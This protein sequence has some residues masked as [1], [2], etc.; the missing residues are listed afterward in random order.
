MH[1]DPWLLAVVLGLL[2]AVAHRMGDYHLAR[3]LLEESLA[4]CR[5]IRDYAN[6]AQALASLGHL[7][8]AIGDHRAARE[9]YEDSLR[10]YRVIGDRR[11]IALTL[12]NLGVVAEQEGDR[13]GARRLYEESLAIVRAIGNPRAL[14]AVLGRLA[15]LARAQG[16][17]SA[18]RAAYLECL[19][20]WLQLGDRRAVLRCLT[21]CACLLATEQPEPALRLCAAAE[22]L[23]E[24]L[25][26][27]PPPAEWAAVERAVTALRSRLGDGP[28]T[29]AGAAGR[30]LS[31]EAAIALARGSLMA[32]QHAP[33]ETG[34]RH[35]SGV[36]PAASRLSPREREVAVLVAHGRTN[37][38]IAGELMI[39]E[40]T[41]D[42]H[43]TNILNKLGFATRAQIAAW[44]VQEGLM[45]AALVEQEL[46]A[47]ST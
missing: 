4:I 10:L 1:R 12:G 18:T 37:R 2:G 44:A 45:T 32:M 11:G 6:H 26:A 21:D 5:E 22:A 25:E 34:V 31:L 28:A 17:L 40:R 29:A 46:S 33:Q 14:P 43:L 24:Q 7:E 13:S 42:T 47:A 8:R 19:Q 3:S 41:A 20:L 36:V 39:A 38:E 9:R 23:L 27:P 35:R 16:D 30:R 15:G